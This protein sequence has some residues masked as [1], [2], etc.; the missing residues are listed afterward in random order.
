MLSLLCFDNFN[1]KLFMVCHGH[2]RKRSKKN[3]GKQA[4][5]ISWKNKKVFNTSRTKIKN[6]CTKD[7]N[8]LVKL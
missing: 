6:L 2:L 4:Y 1:M 3:L 7:L 8:A 5:I